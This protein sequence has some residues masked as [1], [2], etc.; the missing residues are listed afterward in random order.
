MKL[1]VLRPRRLLNETPGIRIS[2]LVIKD[3]TGVVVGLWKEEHDEG[4]I[5]LNR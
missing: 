3:K 4:V 2:S 5:V 1:A